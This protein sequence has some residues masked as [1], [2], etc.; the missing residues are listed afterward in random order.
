M[1]GFNPLGRIRV[2]SVGPLAMFV[3]GSTNNGDVVV[4]MVMLVHC[5]CGVMGVHSCLGG[6]G[7]AHS[8]FGLHF[9][10]L[11]R[12]KLGKV[13]ATRAR[14][15]CAIRVGKGGCALGCAGENLRSSVGVPSGSLVFFGRTCISKV[16]D[17]V[18]V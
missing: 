11:L 10:S 1:G 7:V 5:V 12:S 16:E 8:P 14:V 18:P 6:T 3:N 2:S 4:G 13:V 9:G 17:L 15:C